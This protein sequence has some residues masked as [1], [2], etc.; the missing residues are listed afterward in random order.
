M[1]QLYLCNVDML[2][3]CIVSNKFNLIQAT[4]VSHKIQS[5]KTSLLWCW[6]NYDR[7]K[8]WRRGLRGEI[9][10]FFL[11]LLR[12]R[13]C[14]DGGGG[15]VNSSNTGLTYYDCKC[16]SRVVRMTHKVV[17]SRLTTLEMS[18][19][20]LENIYSTSITHDDR[21]M[22]IVQDTDR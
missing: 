20:L 19:M 13:G 21:S 14:F 8:F 22:F 6:I 2:Y 15:E 18:F 10:F 9:S 12:R 5:S 7:K 16:D 17:A 3:T 1:F 11:L 4:R